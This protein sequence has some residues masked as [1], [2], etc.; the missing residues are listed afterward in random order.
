MSEIYSPT[1]WE[2]ETPASS[3]VKY[4]IIDDVKGHVGDSAT[5]A[6]V[7]SI[8]PGTPV[9]ATKLQK[10]E[11]GLELTSRQS[12]RPISLSGGTKTLSSNSITIAPEDGEGLYVIDTESGAAQGYLDTITGGA[13]GDEIRLIAASAAR[14]VQIRSG[15]DNITCP[16]GGTIN[17]SPILAITVRNNGSGWVVITV[18]VNDKRFEMLFNNS[19]GSI[20]KGDIVVADVSG[21]LYITTTTLTHDPRAKG[22]VADA[23]IANQTW[24]WVQTD[25]HC[26]TVNVQGAVAIGD[27]LFP[28]STVKRAYANGTGRGEGTIGFA[29]SVNASGA[30]TVSAILS[31]LLARWGSAVLMEGVTVLVNNVASGNVSQSGNLACGTNANRLVIAFIAALHQNG[32]TSADPT[33]TVGGA[34]MTSLAAIQR[35]VFSVGAFSKYQAFKYPAPSTGSQSINTGTSSGSDSTSNSIIGI[36]M[37]FSGVNQSTPTGTHNST[38]NTSSTPGVNAT[39]AVAGC[40][41]AGC[42]INGNTSNYTDTGLITSSGAGQTKQGSNYVTSGGADLVGQGDTKTASGATEAMSWGLSASVKTIA[43]SVPIL[44]A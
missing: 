3:P 22:V 14:L 1:T 43:A 4:Q 2:D 13:E 7:T 21:A 10:V 27:A 44:P 31:I 40:L 16:F 34:G 5:I 36:F 42:V 38:N 26:E 35:T 28:S 39:D 8:T 24:G 18:G 25:G 30:G 29:M 37:A 19:G 12:V 33:P 17:L 11:D 9:N 20:V 6:P 41:M 23:S 15:E 32:T